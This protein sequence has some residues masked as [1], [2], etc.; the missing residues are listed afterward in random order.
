MYNNQRLP[1]L[2]EDDLESELSNSSN[3]QTGAARSNTSSRTSSVLDYSAQSFA[4]TAGQPSSQLTASYGFTGAVTLELIEN[5]L[6]PTT[7]VRRVEPSRL[8]LSACTLKTATGGYGLR[9]PSKVQRS[10]E[11][12]IENRQMKRREK[13]DKEEKSYRSLREDFVRE[14]IQNSSTV[15]INNVRN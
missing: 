15:D 7:S 11:S 10:Y 13:Q 1:R 8:D 2:Q 4:Q 12:E 9:A 5:F 6:N 3:R 14:L